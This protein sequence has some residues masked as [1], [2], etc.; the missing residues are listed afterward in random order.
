MK[1]AQLKYDIQRPWLT[2]DQWQKDYIEAEGNCFLLCGRQSGKSAGASIKFGK[3][4]ATKKNQSI[5]MIGYTEKQAFN[6]FFKTLQYL[7]AVY[8]KKVIERGKDKPTKHIINLTNGS[9]IMCYA[10]GVTGD[11][12]RG[13]TITSLVIDEAAPMAREVFQ[14]VSPMISIT[15]GT[16]DIL[17]TPRGKEGF[18]YDCSLRDDFTKFYV[19]AEDCLRHTK[20]FLASEKAWMSDLMYAQEYL[21]EFMDDFKRVFSDE[22]VKQVCTLSVPDGSGEVP[23]PLSAE[24]DYFFGGDVGRVYD[25]STFEI[26]DG[27]DENNVVQKY[28]NEIRDIKIPETFREIRRLERIYSFNRIGIDSGGMGAGVLD[29]LLEDDE[30]KRKSEG[31]D[32]ASKV[33]DDEDKEKPLLKIDMYV[34]LL[35]KGQKGEI[36][37]YN[38]DEI[39][40][41]L[42]SVQWDVS[43]EKPR[44]V[45][46]NAHAVE[47][48]MRALYLIK[49]KLLKPFITSC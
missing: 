26:L 17:S 3:R 15:S 33:I 12:L 38:C 46:T 40:S 11:G 32:N 6:L 41:S 43:K 35:T 23:N 37:L 34:N 30:T 49:Q 5:L 1:D 10:A 22:W 45:G 19:S 44:I 25:P 28:H 42:K 14:A 21:A 39:V 8:P 27:T 18:F 29:L 24:R 4:A 48:V 36:K 20:E 31:L 7:R 9:Q 16:M 2:L 13:P 47:G